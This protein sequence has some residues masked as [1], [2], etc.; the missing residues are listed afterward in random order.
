MPTRRESPPTGA[1]RKGMRAAVGARNSQPDAHVDETARVHSSVR[2]G[3]GVHVGAGASIGANTVLGCNVVIYPDTRIGRDCVIFDNAVL[4]RPPLKATVRGRTVN[5]SLAPLHIG[6]R[7][8]VGACAVIYKGVR[9]G[10]QA[11]IG[12]GASIREEVRIGREVLIARGVT[13]NYGAVIRDRVRIM[14]NA[15][16]TGNTLIESDA[17]VSTNVS[18]TNDNAMAV[19]S[20]KKQRFAGPTIRRGASLGANCTL[21]PGVIIGRGA[22]VAAGAVVTRNVPAGAT[23]MGV[24]A[25]SARPNSPS[26]GA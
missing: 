15:H 7:C 25:R 20:P 10:Q 5:E 3:W 4:G 13:V 19:A 2:V 18:T 22:I 21:L 23:V 1:S 16:I 11:L 24:P 6:D 8:V 26:K 9:V 17:F 14:D 12:D